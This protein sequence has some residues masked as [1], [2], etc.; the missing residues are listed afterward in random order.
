V[1]RATERARAWL[2]QVGGTPTVPPGAA[3]TVAAF[4][5]LG[6]GAGFFQNRI[7][8]QNGGRVQAGN[9]PGIA[10]F[11]RFVFGPGGVSNY[12]F[13]IDN[14]T[15]TA[16]PS[17][18]AQGHVSGWGLVKAIRQAVGSITSSGDFTWTATPTDKLTVA[19][20]TLVNPTTVGADVAGMM[21]DF[22]PNH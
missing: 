1:I 9:S 7:I 3:T 8:T 15:G 14:A 5:S 10:S 22:D 20:D 13:A 12:V 2:T 4:G 16:W 6:K 19:I 21:A 17:P 18:D 11:G